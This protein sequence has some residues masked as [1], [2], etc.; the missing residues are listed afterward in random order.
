MHSQY[1]QDPGSQCNQALSTTISPLQTHRKHGLLANAQTWVGQNDRAGRESLGNR[2][3]QIPEVSSE[4]CGQET[5][6]FLLQKGLGNTHSLDS[7][8][9][10]GHTQKKLKSSR[11]RLQRGTFCHLHYS[12]SSAL[13][14]L[15]TTAKRCPSLPKS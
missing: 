4:T 14:L 5:P 8:Q 10:K 7:P 3:M 1:F 11:T 15:R 12:S 13:L 6:R 2:P 9:G